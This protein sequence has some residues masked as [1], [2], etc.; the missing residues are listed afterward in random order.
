MSR[1]RSVSASKR[2]WRFVRARAHL[3]L[4]QAGDDRRREQRVAGGDGAHGVAQP[5]GRGVLEEE[6]AR[7]GLQ[8]ARDELVVVVAGD[9]QDPR[10][11]ARGQDQLRR[12]DAV[13]HRH[14]E[15]H[16]HDVGVV[17]E[18]DF[19]ALGAVPGL[20][21][22]LE[23]GLGV[24]QLAHAAAHEH[25]VV[26]ED[27]PCPGRGHAAG[28]AWTAATESSAARSSGSV[29]G[30]ATRLSTCSR[31]AGAIKARR[32]RSRGLDAARNAAPSVTLAP[33]VNRAGGGRRRP[34]L[35]RG[36]RA[37]RRPR[38]ARRG[39]G[40]RCPTSMQASTSAY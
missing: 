5:V 39:T 31:P 19:D 1:S 4:H 11:A 22:H 12:L 17:L 9:D 38:G 40:S 7:A 6:A 14:R 27:D 16:Q 29:E 33:P 20:A 26:D 10:L 37:A 13:E 24:E 3:H 28:T 34:E 36:G 25:V 23:V 30:S 18:R 15:V 35:H 8:C 2:R 21:G 32:G